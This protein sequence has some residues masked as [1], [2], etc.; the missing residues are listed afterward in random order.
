MI[1]ILVEYFNI[2]KLK[3]LG[4]DEK[5]GEKINFK[6]EDFSQKEPIEKEFTLV[7][8][9]KANETSI[10]RKSYSAV[11]SKQ[12]MINTRDISK[13]DFN[14]FIRVEGEKN[15][16]EEELKLKVDKIGSDI[17]LSKVDIIVNEDYINSMKPEPKILI[18]GVVIAIIV[19]LST[20]LVIYNI[21]YL[22]IVS[23]VQEFG[24]L[25]AIGATKKQIKAIVFKEGLFLA[26][27]A[28]PMG[29]LLGYV[30]GEFI[31]SNFM[32]ISS[33][34][35]KL[36]III[37]VVVVSLITV[38]VSLLK[39]MKVASKISIVEALRY[40]G[41]ENTGSKTRKGYNE[42]NLNKLAYANLS[43]NKKRTYVTIISLTLSGIIFIV[44]STILNSIDY[45]LTIHL[46][47]SL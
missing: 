12:Y 14:V 23:K 5:L 20:I 34:V 1:Q 35:S 3:K 30:I 32:M 29:V 43:R 40:N 37:P 22:S 4:Y 33:R 25:R 8:I 38:L 6:Y 7:G 15:L 13:E 45:K 2:F 39:P 44:M 41:D 16:S 10:A 11:I 27:I 46:E 47:M 24:K 18:G 17:G 28:I 21:F 36:P 42:I 19:I 9:T 26:I 31:V